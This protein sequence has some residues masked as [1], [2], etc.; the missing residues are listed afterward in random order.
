MYLMEV[1]K[2]RSRNG[3]SQGVSTRQC[4]VRFREQIPP[5]YESADAAGRRPPG[6]LG[7]EQ[8][9]RDQDFVFDEIE[10]EALDELAPCR[11][12]IRKG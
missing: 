3:A 10:Q 11:R 6:H 12:G 5:R 4:G 8:P 7:Y 1:A 2:E 9:E